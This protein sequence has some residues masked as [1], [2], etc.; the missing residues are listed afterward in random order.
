MRC[1]G[2]RAKPVIQRME[3]FDDHATFVRGCIRP[4]SPTQA[5]RLA[6]LPDD[7]GAFAVRD[8]V[9]RRLL[10]ASGG[11]Y[12]DIFAARCRHDVVMSRRDVVIRSVAAPP[13]AAMRSKGIGLLSHLDRRRKIETAPGSWTPGRRRLP[14]TGIAISDG[15]EYR[16]AEVEEFI[17]L[18]GADAVSGSVVGG[19]AVEIRPPERGP[20]LIGE[21]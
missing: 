18:A 17:I 4:V 13:I 5:I 12:V 20:T 14:R 9:I 19:V 10:S 6:R 15:F 11:G 7:R 3:T 16:E 2:L 8:V 1:W 21:V